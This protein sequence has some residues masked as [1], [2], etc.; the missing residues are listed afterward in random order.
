MSIEMLTYDAFGVR[1]DISAEAARAVARRLHL[2]RSRSSDGKVLVTVDLDEI[3]HRRRP[4]VGRT[5]K[6]E[7]LQAEVVR[8]A[9]TVAA[10]R[11]DFERERERADHLAAELARLTAETNSVVETTRGLEGEIAALRIGIQ[12]QPPSRLG[13]LTASV[14]EAD[15]R[16]CR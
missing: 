16:A 5:V 14:V 3:R 2:P 13:R 10:H 1:L 12:K 11:T 8:L 15:R 4:P 7:M 6:I 9:S